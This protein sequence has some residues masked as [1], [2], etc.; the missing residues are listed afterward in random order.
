[1]R[2]NNVADAVEAIEWRARED[3]AVN[4]LLR[5][6]DERDEDLLVALNNKS[7][8]NTSGSKA[9]RWLLDT[10][11]EELNI[12]VESLPC[13]TWEVDSTLEEAVGALAF[14]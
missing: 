10:E 6:L 8:V 4:D 3:I 14:G 2:S 12:G 11:W 13:S 5:L 9:E 1:M 7:R